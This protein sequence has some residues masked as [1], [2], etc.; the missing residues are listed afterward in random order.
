VVLVGREPAAPQD[1]RR[2]QSSRLAEAASRTAEGFRGANL[3]ESEIVARP[4]TGPSRLRWR[5]NEA[6]G[7][8]RFRP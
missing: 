8:F 3:E 4:Q 7:Y 6:F 2:A 5:F 1:V